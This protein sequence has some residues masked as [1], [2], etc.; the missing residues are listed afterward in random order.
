MRIATLT[1]THTPLVRTGTHSKPLPVQRQSRRSLPLSG[2]H[3][4]VCS[5]FIQPPRRKDNNA[6]ERIHFDVGSG[7]Q[8]G[9]RVSASIVL[10]YRSTETSVIDAA[11]APSSFQT[12]FRHDDICH[13]PSSIEI[14]FAGNP[15]RHA[16]QCVCST[17]TRLLSS[18]SSLRHP[19]N[20]PEQS[21][22]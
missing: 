6:P 11:K 17:H 12:R 2:S 4:A 13:Q 16:S 3:L 9:I 7:D 18:P 21:T 8:E 1:E 10:L 19:T 14:S 5:L 20:N 22:S 15:L